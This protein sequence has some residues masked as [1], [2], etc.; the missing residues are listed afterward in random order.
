LSPE[1]DPSLHHCCH[2]DYRSP[3]VGNQPI[4]RPHRRTHKN[5]DIHVW[6]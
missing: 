3:Y 6:A 1:L 5:M 4:V 2:T